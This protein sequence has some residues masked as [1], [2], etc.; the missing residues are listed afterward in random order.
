MHRVWVVKVRSINHILD[1]GMF[2][3]RGSPHM[4]LLHYLL[5]GICEV[6]FIQLGCLDSLVERG[7]EFHD[8]IVLVLC[9]ILEEAHRPQIVPMLWILLQKPSIIVLD[10]ECGLTDQV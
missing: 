10:I 7:V 5:E 6:G 2:L 1:V 4:L 3:I 8:R 9:E